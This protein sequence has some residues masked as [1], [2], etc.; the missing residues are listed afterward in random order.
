[1]EIWRRSWRAIV[2]EASVVDETMYS[3]SWSLAASRGGWWH[4][5]SSQVRSLV[6][7]L[8]QRGATQAHQ[9]LDLPEM[10]YF[11]HRLTWIHSSFTY[12]QTHTHTLSLW[13]LSILHTLTEIV[14]LLLQPTTL[15][16][17]HFTKTR[18]D[19]QHKSTILN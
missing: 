4:S 13:K 8:V 16:F 14:A 12:T 9:S 3:L 11:I 6:S 19:A 18:K 17:W 7:V 1:M 2:R 10:L 5:H 15:I